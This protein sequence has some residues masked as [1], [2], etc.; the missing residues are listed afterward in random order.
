LEESPVREVSVEYNWNS[1]MTTPHLVCYD[2]NQWKS[3][4][5]LSNWNREW[6]ELFSQAYALE[7][8]S[9]RLHCSWMDD[10]FVRQFLEGLAKLPNIKT[11]HITLAS[12]NKAVPNMLAAFSQ[13]AVLP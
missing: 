8:L 12:K 13:A 10:Q 5:Q 2:K 9:V 6:R 7:K 1:M 4:Q 3:L 11:V